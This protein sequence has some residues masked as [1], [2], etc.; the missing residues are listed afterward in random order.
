MILAINTAQREHELAL[1]EKDRI[2]I[3]DRWTG[4][5]DD[6]ERL[7]PTL[8]NMLKKIRRKKEEIKDIIVVKGPGP[9]TAL[10][11]GVS[12]AKALAEGLQANLHGISTFELMKLKAGNNNQLMVILFS[13]GDNVAVYNEDE[14]FIT[15]LRSA[16]ALH[17][18][19]NHII[20]ADLPENLMEELNILCKEKN[21]RQIKVEDALSMGEV[22]IKQKAW[23]IDPYVEEFYLRAP[24]ITPS[25]NKWKQA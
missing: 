8:R 5:R 13:G 21:R 20:I 11:I 9:Y 24:N 6:V 23:E 19:K 12:F 16:M 25:T 22:F 17:Q 1:L 14:Y 3:E 18:F 4:S 2:L 15:S 7:V 10:R